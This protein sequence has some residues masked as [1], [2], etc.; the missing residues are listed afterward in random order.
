[1]AMV[2]A[3]IGLKRAV[4]LGDMAEWPGAPIYD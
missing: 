1:L 3:F 4:G 2:L